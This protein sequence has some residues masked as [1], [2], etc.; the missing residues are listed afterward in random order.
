M[1]D[2]NSRM[3]ALSLALRHTRCESSTT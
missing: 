1:F 3:L 2:P